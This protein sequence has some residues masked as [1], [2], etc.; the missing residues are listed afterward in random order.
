[1]AEEMDFV[2]IWSPFHVL[3][4]QHIQHNHQLLDDLL[5]QIFVSS[6]HRYTVHH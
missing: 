3:F 6:I 1:M 5:I 4:I 2:A